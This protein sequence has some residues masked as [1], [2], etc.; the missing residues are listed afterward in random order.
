MLELFDRIIAAHCCEPGRGL[1]IGALTS[2]HFANLYLAGLDRFLLEE[3][4]VGGM[5]RYMDDVVVWG[6]TRRE[7]RGVFAAARRYAAELLRL[8]IKPGW[9][10]QRSERGV[11]L[12]G[13]RV[14][15]GS[16][17]LSQRR[18]RRYRQARQRWEGHY[19]AG[20]IDVSGLQAGYA[21]V[22]AVTVG[23]DSAAWRRRELDRRPPVEA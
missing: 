3:L 21:S 8:E 4:R 10:P 11:T 2:Q 12:C 16:L 14:N 5:V 9:Q 20:R 17:R 6:R 19:T 23:A 18:R 13:F 1:P 15:P 22:L 7:L